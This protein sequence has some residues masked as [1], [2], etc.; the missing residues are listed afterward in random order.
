M[1]ILISR[2]AP[3][4]P[5][6]TAPTSDTG[7]HRERTDRELPVSKLRRRED[8]GGG[9]NNAFPRAGG[10]DAEITNTDAKR[11]TV[12]YA[13]GRLA[14]PH[15]FGAMLASILFVVGFCWS[16]WWRRFASA[17]PPRLRLLATG[18]GTPNVTAVNDKADE[19][20]HQPV[21]STNASY[22]CLG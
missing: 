22:G 7:A 10:D 15:F 11:L 21:N 1:T 20:K 18:P 3:T 2:R 8:G 5:T 14:V 17:A 12:E 9:E 19:H 6:S 4:W 16:A 13:A